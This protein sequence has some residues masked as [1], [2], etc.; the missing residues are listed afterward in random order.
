MHQKVLSPPRFLTFRWLC[1][2]LGSAQLGSRK[3]KR[4]CKSRRKLRAHWSK[5]LWC[6]FTFWFLFPSSIMIGNFKYFL[7]SRTLILVHTYVC[8]RTLIFSN[9]SYSLYILNLDWPLPL[10][11]YRQ[12]QVKFCDLFWKPELFLNFTATTLKQNSKIVLE[13]VFAIFLFYAC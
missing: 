8:S 5:Q 4:S 1:S 7:K 9:K 3:S 11:S 13:A 6:D 12:I 10:L 2:L